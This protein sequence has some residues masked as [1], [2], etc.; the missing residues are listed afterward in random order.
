MDQAC[1][2]PGFAYPAHV[3]KI[4]DLSFF[5][6]FLF[7][8]F[9]LSPPLPSLPLSLPPSFSFFYFFPSKE[10]WQHWVCSSS[11]LSMSPLSC[12]PFELITAS[13]TL[14]ALGGYF[15]LSHDPPASY[16][17]L[18]LGHLPTSGVISNT[19]SLRIWSF[20]F[21]HFR[22]LWS[23]RIRNRGKQSVRLNER[24]QFFPTPSGPPKCHVA[25]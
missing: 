15:T 5:F 19:R 22:D 18:T 21:S 16:R 14:L 3:I 7:P 12:V 9:P 13:T 11:W 6:I 25:F 1:P 2:H 20:L 24:V 4:L 10:L 23:E 8:S 17:W